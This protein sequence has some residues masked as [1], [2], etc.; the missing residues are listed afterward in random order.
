MGQLIW[1]LLCAGAFLALFG[2]AYE[3]SFFL[4]LNLSPHAHLELSHYLYSGITLVLPWVVGLMVVGGL[5]K[6]FSRTVERDDVE[7]MQRIAKHMGFTGA[8]SLCRLVFVIMVVFWLAVCFEPYFLDTPVLG[9]GFIW[10]ILSVGSFFPIC[11]YVA[12][13]PARP[14][15][16]VAMV[17]SILLCI[18]AVAIES[19]RL[20]KRFG[21]TLRNDGIVQIKLNGDKY[22]V[23]VKPVNFTPIEKILALLK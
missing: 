17:L 12:P 3:A 23:T 2:Y 6:F 20:S 18:S 19:A 5:L 14:A 21:T 10:P 13:A 22:E 11:L 7:E 4:T 15:V 8:L 9:L 16:F 1:L